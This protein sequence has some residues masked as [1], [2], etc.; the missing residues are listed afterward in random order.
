MMPG[1]TLHDLDETDIDTL[2]PWFFWKIAE[3]KKASGEVG[4]IVVRD[5]KQYR[6]NNNADWA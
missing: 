2:F 3:N 5:G 4:E 1:T 6:V